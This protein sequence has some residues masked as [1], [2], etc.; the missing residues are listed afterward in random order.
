MSVKANVRSPYY[1]KFSDT[2]LTSVSLDL[3]VYSGTVTVDKGNVLYN[4][5]NDVIDGTDYVVFEVSDFVRDF[6]QHNFNGIYANT[7]YWFTAEATLYNGTSVISTETVDR[8][9]FDGFTDFADGLNAEGNR[10]E[11][12]TTRTVRIPEGQIYRLPVFSEEVVSISEYVPQPT[13][14]T[15]AGSRWN[16][17]TR[18]W[19]VVEDYWDTQATETVEVVTETAVESTSKVQYLQIESN[20]AR[21]Q[22]NTNT[23]NYNIIIDEIECH[24][25]GW[26]KITFINRFGVLQDMYFTGKKEEEISV[27]KSNYKANAIDFGLLSYNTTGGQNNTFN[28]NSERLF[29][30]NTGFIHEDE[31][32]CLEQ[33]LMSENV[34]MTN[35]AGVVSKVIP[36]DTNLKIQNHLNDKLI[37]VTLT[38]KEAFDNINTV[39]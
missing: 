33:I 34:W 32:S 21:V 9:A 20:V 17:E 26:D 12:I 16:E 39:I 10:D 28:V 5:T 23:G 6:I 35:E 3:Y 15:A 2:N 24:K 13:S 18:Q 37:N 31:M 1:L 38:F 8:L 19:E 22:V 29:T 27:S 4:L 30:L 11:L 36:Q 25:Y 14:A 7:P